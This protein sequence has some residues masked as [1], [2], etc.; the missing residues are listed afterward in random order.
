M[1]H[2]K[3]MTGDKM[4]DLTR[5]RIVAFPFAALGASVVHAPVWANDYPNRVVRLVVPFGPGG[6]TDLV[7]R[8]LASRLST[9]LGQQMI[10]ENRAGAGGIVGQMNVRESA[11]DGYSLL[12]AT[13]GFGANPALYRF[14][15]LPFDP[16]KDF[17]PIVKLVDVPTALVVNPKVGVRTAAELIA[18]ARAKPDAL[19]YGSAGYGTINHLA[20]E[21]FKAETGIKM[22]HVPYKS[23]GASVQAA[24]TGEITALFA[25]VPSSIGFIKSGQLIPIAV[26]SKDRIPLLPEVPPLADTVPGFNVAEW[27]GIVGPLGMPRDIVDKLNREVVAALKDPGVAKRLADM[28]A[29]PVGS[30]PAQFD[31]LIKAEV[32]RLFKVA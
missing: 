16:T 7:A 1:P 14:R 24:V 6:A 29:Q 32:Q 19:N 30:T 9:T 13:I 12:M 21:L 10:V 4:T 5:R 27:Q 18:L 8:V 31:A 22:V 2:A 15:T 23:G 11:P 20:G 3:T 28:G 17:T 26:S 25:T